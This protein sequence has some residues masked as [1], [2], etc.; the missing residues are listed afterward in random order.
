MRY[1]GRLSVVF[2]L[3]SWIALACTMFVGGLGT[4]VSETWVLHAL[5]L[6]AFV[7]ALLASVLGIV[8]M[9]IR[10]QRISALIGLGLGLLFLLMFTGAIWSVFRVVK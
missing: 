8:A 1:A 3:L 2:G 7:A 10:S 6:G 5:P 9:V 4:S